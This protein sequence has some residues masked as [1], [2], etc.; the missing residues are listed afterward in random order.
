MSDAEARGARGFAEAMR[1]AL[2]EAM[3]VADRHGVT[4]AQVAAEL[5]VKPC[6][7]DSWKNP[8]TQA[9]IPTIK[10]VALLR[11]DGV[12]PQPAKVE[13][14]NRLLD[15]AGIQAS[16]VDGD[17]EDTS[18]PVVQ[19]AEVCAE[20]G[21]LSDRIGRACKRDSDG[22]ERMTATEARSA[23]DAAQRLCD[24]LGELR[25]TLQSLE[26]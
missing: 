10:L 24:Q 11:R 14:V 8:S 5:G 22:G 9:I 16:I 19:L 26:Q 25:R 4:R 13:L 23:L 7:I 12:L 6:T 20:M 18:A 1:Q 3:R 15:V 2:F 17:C 21:A